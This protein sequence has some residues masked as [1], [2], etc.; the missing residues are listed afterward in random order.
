M[1]KFLGMK[2]IF[3]TTLINVFLANKVKS[4]PLVESKNNP[5]VNTTSISEVNAAGVSENDPSANKGTPLNDIVFANGEAS[6]EELDWLKAGG[7]SFLVGTAGGAALI[8]SSYLLFSGKKETKKKTLKS[9]TNAL[10]LDNDTLQNITTPEM[11]ELISP[12]KNTEGEKKSSEIKNVLSGGNKISLEMENRE[13]ESRKALEEDPHK[14][15]DTLEKK[16]ETHEKNAQTIDIKIKSLKNEIESLKKNSIFEI[17]PE[18]AIPK[19]TVTANSYASYHKKLEEKSKQIESLKTQGEN[20]RTE[21]VKC[22]KEAEIHRTKLEELK[23]PI[24]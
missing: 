15:I 5:S 13:I 6:N 14:K 20:S 17:M 12:Q 2:V 1:I 10:K 24:I 23:E 19:G 11:E 4:V 18:N 21:A 3:F 9:E 16:A 22:R 7:T 8:G